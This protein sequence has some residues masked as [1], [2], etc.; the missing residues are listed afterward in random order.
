MF[1]TPTQAV[2]FNIEHHPEVHQFKQCTAAGY[3]DGIKWLDI[4]YNMSSLCAMYFI[5]LL[6]M[7]F[8]YAAIVIKVSGNFDAPG[9]RKYALMSSYEHINSNDTDN[10]RR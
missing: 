1:A 7:V 3:F 5:P 6:I 4:T 10:A 9:E 2:I 8:C